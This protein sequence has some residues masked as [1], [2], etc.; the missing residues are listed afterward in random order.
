AMLPHRFA[1]SVQDPEHAKAVF[2]VGVWLSASRDA[3]QEMFAL[4]A[5]RLFFL[6]RHCFAL[7]AARNRHAVN[8]IDAMRIE[9]E[10]R[11]RLRII[12]DGHLAVAYHDE[13][14]LLVWM[15]PA[16]ENVRLDATGEV[17]KRQRDVRDRMAQVAAALRCNSHRVFFK[18]MNDCGNIVRRE[19]PQNI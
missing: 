17:E 8:P 9:D 11:V 13:L 12:E 19:T 18:Q 15:E 16:D 6:K 10:L 5:K 14:L 2:A 4:G 1:G 3:L 7:H